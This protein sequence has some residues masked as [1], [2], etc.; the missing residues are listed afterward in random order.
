MLL[1]HL[2]LGFFKSGFLVYL[3]LG[4]VISLTILEGV[5]SQVGRA[6]SQSVGASSTT[7][8]LVKPEPYAQWLRLRPNAQEGFKHTLSDRPVADSEHRDTQAAVSGINP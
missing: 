6:E 1:S 8:T 5:Y 4:T 7:V 2:G 3:C